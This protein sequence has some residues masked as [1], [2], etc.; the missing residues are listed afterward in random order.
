MGWY[1]IHDYWTT[2]KMEKVRNAYKNALAELDGYLATINSVME[3]LPSQTS[4]IIRSLQSRDAYDPSQGRFVYEFE[5]KVSAVEREM[6]NVDS[7][8]GTLGSKVST[9]RSKRNEVER[10]LRIL[11]NLCA[12]EDREEKELP[13]SAIQF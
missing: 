1:Q 12:R 10:R 9:L 8:S 2:S 4:Q 11:N 7:S 3:W 5:Q 13:L 6:N